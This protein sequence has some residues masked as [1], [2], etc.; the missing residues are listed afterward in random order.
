MI[1]GFQNQKGG[2]GKSTLATNCAARFA[3]ISSTTLMD[4]DPQ[5]SSIK[6]RGKRAEELGSPGFSTMWLPKPIVHKE[7]EELQK[8]HDFILID[9]AGALLNSEGQRNRLTLSALLAVDIVIVPVLASGADID[10]T[11]EFLD[12]VE[13]ARMH[14]PNLVSVIV[15]NRVEDNTVITR[16]YRDLLDQEKFPIMD[17]MIPKSVT[18]PEALSEGK[19]VFEYGSRAAKASKAI[20]SLVDEIIEIGK[21]LGVAA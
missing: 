11:I 13:E 3:Q 4:S 19:T 10:S 6:W 1:I 15:W 17:T 20:I 5:G 18:F 2:V 14:K 7:V 8:N 12:V 9:A 21:Q 16:Q